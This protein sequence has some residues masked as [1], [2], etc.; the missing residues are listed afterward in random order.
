MRLHKQSLTSRKARRSLMIR[1]LM[2]WV[3]AGGVVVSFTATAG[4]RTSVDASL[5]GLRFGEDTANHSLAWPTLTPPD[6]AIAQEDFLA[7]PHEAMTVPAEPETEEEPQLQPGFWRGAQ[8][9]DGREELSG[10]T[11]EISVLFR[12]GGEMMPAAKPFADDDG[13]P[14]IGAFSG[15]EAPEAAIFTENQPGAGPADTIV[16]ARVSAPADPALIQPHGQTQLG[17]PPLP[18][19]VGP[20]SPLVGIVT[21]EKEMRCLAEAVYFEARSEP[22]RGQAGVAQ[23]VLNRVRSG[24]YPSSVCGVVYQNRH[25]Y[26][27]CQFTFACEGKAL[28]TN[29]AGPWATAQR[30]A[31]DVAEGRTYL[32]GVGNATHYHANYV[33]PW[34]ARY[35]DRREKVGKH[36]FYFESAEN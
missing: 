21:S 9:T 8:P 24:V 34:W 11:P 26:L 6:L 4:I 25:R 33:R 31:R 2:P 27:A 13:G 15:M 18:K 12:L 30:I 29:E 5:P 36:I 17:S 23:V 3:L 35:M 10:A 32:P 20:K 16:V 28:R 7:A 22:E 14:I 1:P 19:P